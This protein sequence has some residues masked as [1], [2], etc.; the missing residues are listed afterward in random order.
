MKNALS[1]AHDGNAVYQQTIREGDI[2]SIGKQAFSSGV[3]VAT[4]VCVPKGVTKA[5]ALPC[6]RD[7]MSIGPNQKTTALLCGVSQSYAS[8]L[9]REKMIRAQR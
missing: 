9:L 8:K 1:I 4:V 3:A 7:L 2:I 6:L 5:E